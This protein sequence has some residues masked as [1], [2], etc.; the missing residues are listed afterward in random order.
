[1]TTKGKFE[2]VRDNLKDAIVN[3]GLVIDYVGHLNQMLERTSEAAQSV[4][5][6]GAK[7]P[8]KNA[9]YMQFCSSK[10]THE[11]VSASPRN[12]VNCPYVV[13]AYELT[14]TPGTIHIG[15]RPP[16]GEPSRLTQQV[17]A[18]ITALLES[19]VKEAVK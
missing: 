1:M 7:T 8:Y 2:D 16:V 19:I 10:L 11:L 15:Y 6:Q 4:T 5:P 18:K 17:N 14:G 13:F 12:I 3:K 9:E